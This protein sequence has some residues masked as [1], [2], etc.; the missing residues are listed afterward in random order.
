MLDLY[1]NMTSLL[2]IGYINLGHADIEQRH[3]FFCIFMLLQ[4]GQVWNTD[5]MQVLMKLEAAC[6][7][8]EMTAS[9]S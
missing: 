4:T 6:V 3:A 5:Y 1:N 8:Q 2:A 9:P 7:C